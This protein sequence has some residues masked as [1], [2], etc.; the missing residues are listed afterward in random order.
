MEA[1]HTSAPTPQG[2]NQTS[3]GSESERRCLVTGEVLP[4]DDLI[5]FVVGPDNTIVP[6]LAQNLPGRGLW[7][8][9]DRASI[10]TASKKNLF[11]KAAKSSVKADASLVDQVV[12]LMRKRCLDFLGLARRSGIAILGEPQ[13][14]AAL[15]A[16]QLKLVLLATDSK[17]DVSSFREGR[18]VTISRH[19]NRNEL[20]AA[21]GHDQLVYLGFKA[22]ALTNKLQ[23]EIARLEKIATPHHIEV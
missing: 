20:G 15:K 22:H 14:E 13:V 23:S 12:Q 9:A 18:S 16:G 1:A 19:F 5:R 17:G 21:L 10:E 4:K 8:K 11:A 6:D 2:D 7:V 3:P